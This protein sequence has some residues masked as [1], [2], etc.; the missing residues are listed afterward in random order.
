MG[1]T[2]GAAEAKTHL[3]RLLKEVEQTRESVTITNRGKALARIVPMEPAE[4][5]PIFG[6]LKGS[7][8]ILGDIVEPMDP[9]WEAEWDANNPP[10]LYRSKTKR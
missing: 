1:K 10:E 8:K 5:P 7:V 4:Q 3:L 9:D 2:I 6:C